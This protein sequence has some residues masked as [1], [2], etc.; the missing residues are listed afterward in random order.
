L[1]ASQR[2]AK[3]FFTGLVAGAA[4]AVTKPVVGILDGA[5]QGTA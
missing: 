3:G 4:G 2:G 5:T 1:V